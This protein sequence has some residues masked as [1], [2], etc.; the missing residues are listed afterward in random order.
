VKR[1]YIYCSAILPIIVVVAYAGRAGDEIKFYITGRNIR[2]VIEH[3]NFLVAS[4]SLKFRIVDVESDADVSIKF[5]DDIGDPNAVG[6]SYALFGQIYIVNSL[7]ADQ[8]YVVL[9]HEILHCAG[10]GHESE[11]P[12]SVMY[13][14]SQRQ[15][16]LKKWHMR[17]L[18]R[19][20]GIT[21]PERFVAQ[22]RMLF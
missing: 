1:F 9:I 8:V 20:A 13:T 14:H 12:S 4:E 10:V 18:R 21:F 2:P 6:V 22:I 7:P 5:Q 17:Y 3:L 11:D 15:G 16:Q 19:L